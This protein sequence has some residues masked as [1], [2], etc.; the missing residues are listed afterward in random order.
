MG[1]HTRILDPEVGMVDPVPER[2]TICLTDRSNQLEIG[3][4]GAA[5]GAAGE[6]EDE[7]ETWWRAVERGGADDTVF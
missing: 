5:T 7:A 3:R 6:E 4:G 1:R 2:S